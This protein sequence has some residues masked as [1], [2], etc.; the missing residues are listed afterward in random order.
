MDGPAKQESARRANIWRGPGLVGAASGQHSR[1]T[2]ENGTFTITVCFGTVGGKKEEKKKEKKK[3]AVL[4]LDGAKQRPR[5]A[6]NT[7]SALSMPLPF[8]RLEDR[9]LRLKALILAVTFPAPLPPRSHYPRR[10]QSHRSPPIHFSLDARELESAIPLLT[11]RRLLRVP[12]DRVPISRDSI[13]S[14][15]ARM[16]QRISP[17]TTTHALDGILFPR[18]ARNSRTLAV[19]PTTIRSLHR[20]TVEC[21]GPA[22]PFALSMK[23]PRRA[24]PTSRVG[25]TTTRSSATFNR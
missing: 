3:I 23:V 13:S 15:R 8:A 14:A 4:V 18:L 6:G 11:S 7:G 16:Q 25:A 2:R 22:A 24:E 17:T 21:P 10:S 19:T 20:P 1:T 12:H 5:N 9:G